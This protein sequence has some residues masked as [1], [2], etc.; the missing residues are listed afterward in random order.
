MVYPTNGKAWQG[1]T[2]YKGDLGNHVTLPLNSADI[3]LFDH[4][5]AIFVISRN[6][7]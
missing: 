7:N 1:Y 4:K 6:K 3:A 5:L 2:V